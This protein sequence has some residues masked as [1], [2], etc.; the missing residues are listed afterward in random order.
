MRMHEEER[1]KK[2]TEWFGETLAPSDLE[3][4]ETFCKKVGKKVGRNK[5]EV[6]K[7]WG[8]CL[9]SLNEGK[10]DALEEVVK[11]PENK[12]KENAT[13]QQLGGLMKKSKTVED[14]LEDAVELGLKRG[15][16][17]NDLIQASHD[18]RTETLHKNGGT[19]DFGKCYIRKLG[20]ILENLPK[21]TERK[22]ILEK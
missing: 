17:P 1:L 3:T 22:D 7:V 18:C 19:D 11:D 2:Y 13:K 5:A 8:T 15:A 21:E 10:W 16:S 4:D 20:D 14:I 9:V 12:E 6:L